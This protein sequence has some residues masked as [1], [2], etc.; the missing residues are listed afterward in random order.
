VAGGA[1]PALHGL[2]H[3]TRH[4]R[5]RRHSEL[6]GLDGPELAELLGRGMAELGAG[7]QPRVFV[8]PFNRFAASQYDELARRFRVVC[9]GPE[10]VREVGFQATPSWSRGAVYLP[11]YRPLYGLADEIGQAL[12]RVI[13]SNPGTWVPVTL[14]LGWDGRQALTRLARAMAPYARPWS[15]LLADADFAAAG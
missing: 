8:P 14:H 10:S 5:P 7:I 11:C 9:G 3:R 2:T 6:H 15:E 12:P 4:A 1:E 13:E